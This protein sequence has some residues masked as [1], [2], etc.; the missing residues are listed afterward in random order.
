[1]K[2]RSRRTGTVV[3]TTVVLLLLSCGDGSRPLSM[4]SRGV[5]FPSSTKN[6]PPFSTSPKPQPS[7][8]SSP[9]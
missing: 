5:S 6:W 2:Q 4:D 1:M 7:E 9:E 3:A 8:I